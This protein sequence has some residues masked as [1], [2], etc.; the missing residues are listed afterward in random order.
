ML[1][2]IL[3]FF[4]LF[5]SLLNAEQEIEWAPSKFAIEYHIEIRDFRTKKIKVNKKLKQTKYKINNLDEGLYEYRIG[6]YTTKKETVYTDWTSLSIT[7]SLEPEA[8]IDEVYYGTL[9]DKYQEIF[10][11]GNNFVEDTKIEVFNENTRLE[12]KRVVVKSSKELSFTID[13]KSAKAGKYDLRIL[14]PLGKDFLKRG[15]YIIGE[16]YKEAENAAKKVDKE[17]KIKKYG[18]DDSTKAGLFARSYFLKSLVLPGWGQIASG[19]DNESKAKRIRGYLYMGLGISSLTLF[20]YNYKLYRAARND[21]NDLEYQNNL[22]N[23]PFNFPLSFYGSYINE[24]YNR[25]LDNLE[26]RYSNT[27]KLGG[28]FLVVYTINLIDAYFFTGRKRGIFNVE[29]LNPNTNFYVYYQPE[30][31]QT[32][33]NGTQFGFGY[34][35]NF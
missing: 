4:L 10:I 27:T 3:L 30:K 11:S 22:T 21:A 33:P 20:A 25:S 9:K 13:L 16:N 5:T 17:E 14:N 31:N 24:K 12:I 6:V 18:E 8:A 29:Y 2:K 34:N 15:F 19:I 26:L 1:N 32:G 23:Q 7:Q 35:F 28:F